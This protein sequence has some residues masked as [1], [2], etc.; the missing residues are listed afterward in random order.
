M[1][2]ARECSETAIEASRLVEKLHPLVL[3]PAIVCAPGV[4]LVHRLV[5][6]HRVR[7]EQAQE[8]ELGES[9]EDQANIIARISQPIVRDEMVKMLGRGEID[10]KSAQAAAWNLENGLTWQQL[11][12]K[13]G[14]KHLNGSVEPYF[15]TI[16]LERALGVTR[17]AQKAVESSKESKP[18]ESLAKE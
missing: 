2:Q 3:E 15:T 18:I 8:A 13:V 7:A 16:H 10:Q 4:L 14:V 17:A 1:A 11:A 9:A 12:A 5:A 6:H